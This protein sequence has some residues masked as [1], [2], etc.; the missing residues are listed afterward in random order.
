MYDAALY[1]LEWRNVCHR[2]EKTVLKK[3]LIS[4]YTSHKTDVLT[5]YKSRASSF[6]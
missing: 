3:Y 2:R 1:A 4:E 5:F 6:Y